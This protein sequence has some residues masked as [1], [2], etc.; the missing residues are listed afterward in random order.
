MRLY[1]A[2]DADAEPSVAV[3]AADT[4]DGGADADVEPS[5]AVD[6]D[7]GDAADTSAIT[8]TELHG[9]DTKSSSRIPGCCCGY[10]DK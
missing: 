2:A 10:R 3:D 6:A 4:A 9:A 5:V 7:A 8:G 1:D